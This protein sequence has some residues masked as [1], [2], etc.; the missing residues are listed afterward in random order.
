MKIRFIVFYQIWTRLKVRPGAAVHAQGFSSR[1][2]AM[3]WIKAAPDNL[4]NITMYRAEEL[5]PRG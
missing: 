2:A 1:S 5:A 4:C 3:A